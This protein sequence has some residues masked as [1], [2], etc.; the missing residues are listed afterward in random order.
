MKRGSVRRPNH[1]TVRSTKGV[2]KLPTEK[3][4]HRSGNDRS[5]VVKSG[6]TG[7]DNKVTNATVQRLERAG[8]SESAK[9]A[10]HYVNR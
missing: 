4:Q 3:E 10:R 2:T 6:K 8:S 9:I 5:P 1:A 7:K